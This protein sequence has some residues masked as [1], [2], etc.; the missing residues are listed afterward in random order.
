MADSKPR[1]A[2]MTPNVTP[3]TILAPMAAQMTSAEGSPSVRRA[4]RCSS[5]KTTAEPTV[6]EA[7]IDV[8]GRSP[9]GR[10]MTFIPSH[11]RKPINPQRMSTS[12]V[13][14]PYKIAVTGL[15]DVPET[16]VN[17]ATSVVIQL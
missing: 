14:P 7:M 15:R 9:R 16:R 11:T 4:G 5:A 8:G 12:S 6:A 13:I 10:R 2:K 17:G 3:A 1:A